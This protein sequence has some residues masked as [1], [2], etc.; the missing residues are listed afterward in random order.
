MS[1]RTEWTPL[2]PLDD[3]LIGGSD[4]VV[5]NPEWDLET[6]LEAP[7]TQGGELILY[8]S[9]VIILLGLGLFCHNLIRRTL[10]KRWKR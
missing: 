5:Q 8:G 3:E 7:I 9:L 2:N 6:W 1:A 4:A 10:E